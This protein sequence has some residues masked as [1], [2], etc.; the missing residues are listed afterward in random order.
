[1]LAVGGFF[2]YRLIRQSKSNAPT[3]QPFSEQQRTTEAEKIK[4]EFEDRVKQA[5]ETD[6]DLDGLSNEEEKKLGTSPDSADTDSDGILDFDEIKTRKTN[7]LKADTDGDGKTDGYEVRRG[8][9]PL[10]K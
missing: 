1:M 8:M 7:P 3:S 2:A 10:K 4:K 5:A 9:N 6:S